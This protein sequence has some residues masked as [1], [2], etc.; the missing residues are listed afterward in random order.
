MVGKHW[1][2]LAIAAIFTVGNAL[3]QVSRDVCTAPLPAI[4]P[5]GETMFTPAQEKELGRILSSSLAQGLYIY[6]DPA[7]V[8]PLERIADRLLLNLPEEDYEF[9]FKVIE[10]PFP[11][12][13]AAPGGYIMVARRLITAAPNEDAI[14]GVLAHEMGHVLARQASVNLSALVRQVLG[15]EELPEDAHL[16]QILRDLMATPEFQEER[17]SSQDDQLVADQISLEAAWRAGYDPAAL[18]EFLDRATGNEGETGNFLTD[19]FGHTRPESERYR[20]MLQQLEEIPVGCRRPDSDAGSEEFEKWQFAAAL[21]RPESESRYPSGPEP[22]VQLTPKL[23]QELSQVKFSPDGRYILAQDDDGLY[24][25]NRS[26]FELVATI[27][28]RFAHPAIFHRD[29]SKVI[30]VD[31]DSRIEIWD[32]EKGEPIAAYE[33]LLP[34][35]CA[36]IQ[37]SP[38]G[39]T[40]ACLSRLNQQVRLVDLA[41][42]EVSAEHTILLVTRD[43]PISNAEMTRYIAER[44]FSRSRAAALLP[45][46]VYVPGFGK[47]SP[48]GSVFLHVSPNY[49]DPAWAFSIDRREEV[50]IEGKL[51]GRLHR[52][53]VLLDDHRVA[54][55]FKDGPGIY[56]F[57]EGDLLREVAIP[58]ANIEATTGGDILLLRGVPNYA[59]MA[60]DLAKGEI[61]Q[62]GTRDALDFFGEW[63]VAERDDGSLALYR[64]GTSALIAQLTLPGGVL[65]KFRSMAVDAEHNWVALSGKTRSR[66]WNLKDGRTI[67]LPPFD[68]ASFS[69]DLLFLTIEDREPNPS[70]AGTRPVH[71]RVALDLSGNE[72]RTVASRRLPQP[73]EDLKEGEYRSII[74][75]DRFVV[76]QTADKKQKS[77]IEVSDLM[78]GQRLWNRELPDAPPMLAGNALVLQFQLEDPSARKIL[79]QNDTL[80]ARLAEIADRNNVVLLEVLALDSGKLLGHVLANKVYQGFRQARLLGRTLLVQ[81]QYGGAEAYH[82]D[83]GTRTWLPGSVLAVDPVQQ[84]V[85]LGARLNHVIV[86]DQD[87]TTQTEFEYPD[88]VVMAGFGPDGLRLVVFTK[89]QDVYTTALPSESV[90]SEPGL[91]SDVSSPTAP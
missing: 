83:Q 70:G 64:R 81:G 2:F 76:V 23:R 59:V 62:G 56:S 58:E 34:P 36:S 9:Q 57:P 32:I 71:V 3:G 89:N 91:A 42:G 84:H 29:S 1:R 88:E 40:I 43:Q 7:L 17:G 44:E 80:S 82:L 66:L 49:T 37:P 45:P 11:T 25:T 10:Y 30:F 53:F 77:R 75:G 74:F 55:N 72:P 5:A 24:V 87:G 8:A 52:D 12:A 22:T 41:S 4:D 27:P 38:D 51:H 47:F 85:A 63:S 6:D 50:R 90:P 73:D 79:K 28:A 60:M 65:R 26:S 14:A 33:P 78:A 13:F 69:D 39:R 67:P 21:A 15:W 86:V 18:P 68:D 35:Q 46:R 19:L 16:E 48:D 20:T 61:F 31:L 54:G